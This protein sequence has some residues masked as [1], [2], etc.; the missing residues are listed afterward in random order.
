MRGRKRAMRIDAVVSRDIAISV[1]LAKKSRSS[2]AYARATE[3][4]APT[5]ASLQVKAQMSNYIFA[6]HK[7]FMG[8]TQLCLTYD[9]SCC[10]GSD[11]MA[12]GLYAAAKNMCM[13][14]P[15]QAAHGPIPGWGGSLWH[16]RSAPSEWICS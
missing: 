13:W 1:I 3:V 9:L 8:D 4:M 16:V 14:L 11:P 6:G 12:I 15:P 7:S 2:V 10:G 5:T